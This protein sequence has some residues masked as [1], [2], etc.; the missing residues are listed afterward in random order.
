MSWMFTVVWCGADDSEET[1]ELLGELLIESSS[2]SS[3]MLLA[4]RAR[5]ERI[6]TGRSASSAVER[7]DALWPMNG[8]TISAED[9][10]PPCEPRPEASLI[11]E[12]RSAG[13]EAV[14]E[15]S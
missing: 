9:C 4:C 13:H 15:S 8:T 12:R 7:R 10:E 3:G 1:S 2:G 11:T 14:I 5:G 6:G